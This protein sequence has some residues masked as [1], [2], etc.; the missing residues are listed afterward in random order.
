MV[1]T[2]SLGKLLLI[3]HIISSSLAFHLQINEI[4]RHHQS[5]STTTLFA[6]QYGTNDKSIGE[7]LKKYGFAG[8]LVTLNH[9]TLSLQPLPAELYD[10][11]KLRLCLIKGLKLPLSSKTTNIKPS[12][13]D[14]LIMD[15]NGL[16]SEDKVVDIGQIT[17]IWNDFYK[18]FHASTTVEL[19]KTLQCKY[20]EARITL[21]NDIL[22]TEK[23]MQN[24]YNSRI[25]N[26]SR[27]P[28]KK[29]YRQHLTKKQIPDIAKQFPQ[30]NHLE[31]L[32]RNLV[33]V[34]EDRSSRMV[35]SALTTDYLYD[36]F[37]REG[38]DAQLIR[39]LIAATVL[40][41][42]ATSGGRF[43]RRSCQFVDCSSIIED[44]ICETTT[45]VNGGWIALDPSVRA[46]TEGRKFAAAAAAAAKQNKTTPVLLTAADERIAHRLECLAMG[47][48]WKNERSDN[49]GDEKSLELD[50]REALS[51][52]SLPPTAEGATRALIQLGRWSQNDAKK[53]SKRA[54][55][56]EPWSID[57]IN[58]AQTL[59]NYREKL[60]SL[61]KKSK[62]KNHQID[63]RVDL[64]SL[65]CVCIDAKR[66]SFRD[67]SIGIR[68]RSS[69]GRKVM[70]SSK[71]E[72]LVHIADVSNIY[73][74]H[75]AQF[76]V[77]RQA[78]EHR[79]QSR[80]D[81]P[82]GPL[83]LLPP[84]ALSALALSTD[85]ENSVNECVTV[86]TYIDERSGKLID[87]GLERTIIGSP[88][89]LSFEEANKLL[90][91]DSQ[92]LPKSLANTRA[93]ITVIERNVSTWSQH[94]RKNSEAAQKREKRLATKELISQELS[95]AGNAVR[96]DGVG[97]SFQ[98]SRGHRVVDSALDLYA[99][100][101]A[102]M[103]KQKKK[104]MP[105]AAGSAADRGGRLC[106]A[107]LRRY[108]DGMGQRQAVAVLCKHGKPL[109]LD[110][111][112]E[113]S[114][115]ASRANDRVANV[116][117]TKTRDG[118]TNNKQRAAVH[119]VAR[120]LSSTGAKKLKAVSSGHNN[121]VVILGTGAVAKCRGVRGTM[122]G[123][124]KVLIE[125]V[126]IDPEKG[127]LDVR[128]SS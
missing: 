123:G 105:R 102:S 69:T 6:S 101:I 53:S 9:G 54:K 126:S 36:N 100:V 61:H 60:A 84:K 96:D 106:T 11:G 29:Q 40:T 86:W 79:G 103:M 7:I 62:Q 67:D 34:G 68:L 93:I 116:R 26:R 58:A 13:L 48:A 4:S 30:F 43:K 87:Y 12:L 91:S 88:T 41:T 65:P 108:I 95:A 25:A 18:H 128:L 22:P 35:D 5:H 46:G 90:E 89:A 104:P 124:K 57:V 78:A 27:P 20:D 16:F 32:L 114:K 10:Q 99:V 83:H 38:D 64:S 74:S 73:L 3:T 70:A 98:R 21:Q 2:F 31:E 121:E 33:K 77:L 49:N 92:Q 28:S 45:L 107:P 118:P 55:I 97:G 59:V 42:D 80:Y 14:V 23:A 82:F 81:L 37:C 113:V 94:R 66:A 119:K 85:N 17:F 8:R 71:W 117:S 39:R 109:T 112:K 76:K 47:D 50:V 63:G 75:D 110:E 56:V 1:L 125:V 120:H 72:I 52:M 127:L 19:V 24:L 122:T 115:L 111:C 51:R 15:E 44:G